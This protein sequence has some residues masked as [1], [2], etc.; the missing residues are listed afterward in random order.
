MVTINGCMHTALAV[1]PGPVFVNMRYLNAVCVFAEDDE[2]EELT[3][4]SVSTALLV[5]SWIVFCLLVQSKEF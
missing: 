4:K 5:P 3:M 1:I 2:D